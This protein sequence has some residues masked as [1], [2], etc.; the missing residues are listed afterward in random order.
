MCGEVFYAVFFD[1]DRHPTAQVSTN[2]TEALSDLGHVRVTLVGR[3]NA[4][5]REFFGKALA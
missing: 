2:H 1:G 4:T 5:A 3:R